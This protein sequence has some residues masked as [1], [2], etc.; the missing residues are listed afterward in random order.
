MREVG[1][2]RTDVIEGIADVIIVR[3]QFRG[4]GRFVRVDGF[5]REGVKGYGCESLKEQERV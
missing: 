2:A 5:A 1:V 3:G 4:E